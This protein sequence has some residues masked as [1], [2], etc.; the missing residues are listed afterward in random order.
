MRLANA[1]RARIADQQL[2]PGQRLPSI[3]TLCREFRL[4]RPTAGKAMRLLADEGLI[5][6]VAGHGYYVR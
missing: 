1:I 5:H 6:R 4:S 3:T 2:L